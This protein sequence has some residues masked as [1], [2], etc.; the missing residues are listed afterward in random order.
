[1]KV[2]WYAD[3]QKQPRPQSVRPQRPKIGTRKQNTSKTS[4]RL[5]R[6]SPTFD[7]PKMW[8]KV[9]EWCNQDRLAI[10]LKGCHGAS[11]SIHRQCV[12][13]LKCG[14]YNDDRICITSPICLLIQAGAPQVFAY[15]HIDQADMVEKDVIRN[16]ICASKFYQIFIL[17]D[18]KS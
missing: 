8:C 7:Q 14:R 2:E 13:L 15:R 12:V 11:Q 17:S 5:H 18:H 4:S 1:M 16:D 6:V 9:K 3:N 10:L